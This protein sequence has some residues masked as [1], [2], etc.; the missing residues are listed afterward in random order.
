MTGRVASDRSSEG[1]TGRYGKE[2]HKEG[3]KQRIWER[4]L[5]PWIKNSV[6]KETDRRVPK[7]A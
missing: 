6:A 3:R 2:F 5:E 1:S 4:R 7:R